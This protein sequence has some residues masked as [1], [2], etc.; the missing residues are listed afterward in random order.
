MRLARSYLIVAAATTISAIAVI[1]AFGFMSFGLYLE[2]ARF[3][4]RPLAA[5]LSGSCDVVFAIL[6]LLIGRKIANSYG[7]RR[8]EPNGRRPR[9]NISA[10]DIPAMIGDLVTQGLTSFRANPGTGLGAAYAA[11]FA[12]GASPRLRQALLAFAK[13]LLS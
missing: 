3:V 13:R 8:A 7:R 12:I 6:V 11:G 2:L 1:V 10:D 4:E 5:V 9:E